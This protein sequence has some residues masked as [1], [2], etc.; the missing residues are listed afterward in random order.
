MSQLDETHRSQGAV[1]SYL[2]SAANFLPQATAT[3]DSDRAP[4][5]HAS[6]DRLHRLDALAVHRRVLLLQ[7]PNGPFF[8]RLARRLE[9]LGAEVTKVHFNGGDALFWPRR[10]AIHFRA[11]MSGWETFVAE[12]L[13]C[14]HVEAIVL[15]GQFRRHH[16]TAMQV[17]RQLGIAIYVFEE[18]YI[19]PWWITLERGGVNA[20]SPLANLDVHTLPTP[21]EAAP[22]QQFRF[23]FA[24]MAVYSFLYFLA[25]TVLRRAY[26]HYVHH[27]P[28]RYGKLIPWLRSGLRK[29]LYRIT[30][31][32]TIRSLLGQASGRYFL[33]PLQLQSDSQFRHH[34]SLSGNEEFIAKAI[35]SFATHA[36]P[37]AK[38]AFKH[39]PMERGHAHYGRLIADLSDRHGIRDRVVYIHD[40]HLPSLLAHA[41]GV[42]VVNSTTGLQ[43][44]HH[45]KPVHVCGRAFYAK[46][47]LVS[48]E[49]LDEFWRRPTPPDPVLVR[50]FLQT[51]LHLS[52]I[53]AS[54]YLDAGLTELPRERASI[55]KMGA[56]A[57]LVAL[58]RPAPE[59]S[60]QC[61]GDELRD[62]VA[63]RDAPIE[64]PAMVYAGND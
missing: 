62:S 12:L 54:F 37:E 3:H 14:R 43:A 9:A 40:G 32:R 31:R 63:A 26:P 57:G 52:Q 22:A 51:V 35:D 46:P 7:G 29:W 45:G 49:S 42:V 8:F 27:R 15:F 34:S 53:N 23:A 64:T 33:A 55:E 38:L 59:R 16:V 28:F 36:P 39:H 41:R 19:R 21:P 1:S 13:V 10:G 11:P 50:R 6:S 60:P 48:T 2:Q 44:L 56:L 30:E 61:G 24:K 58:P 5:Q 47:G 25:G 18:G 4:K 17:A 20:D